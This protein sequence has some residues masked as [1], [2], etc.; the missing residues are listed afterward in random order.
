LYWEAR[1]RAHRADIAEAI[2]AVGATPAAIETWLAA[3][4]RSRL[5]P[6]EDRAG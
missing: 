5:I 3:R 1:L 6:G 4:R 2:D